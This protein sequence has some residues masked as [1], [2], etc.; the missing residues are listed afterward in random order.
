M[1]L[2]A[3]SR[4]STRR[5]RRRW[6]SAVNPQHKA[7]YGLNGTTG[8]QLFSGTDASNI[9]LDSIIANDSESIAAASSPSGGGT[10]AAGNGENAR[11]IAN[12]AYQAVFGTMTLQEHY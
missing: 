7:G 12:I 10:P 1:G 2:R 3:R 4:Y 6:L 8:I 9:A 5:S 11:A